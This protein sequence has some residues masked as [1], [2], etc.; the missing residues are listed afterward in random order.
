MPNLVPLLTLYHDDLSLASRVAL[1]VIRN[2]ALEVNVQHVST[3]NGYR[4][5]EMTVPTLIDHSRNDFSLSDSR[6]IASYL[7]ESHQSG[8]S[9][10]PNDI[11]RRAVINQRLYFDAN[12]LVPRLD[13]ITQPLLLGYTKDIPQEKRDRLK[14]SLGYLNGFLELNKWV[15]G[16]ET[17]IADLVIVCTVTTLKELGVRLDEH[18]FVQVWFERCKELPGFEEMEVG[19]KEWAQDVKAKMNQGYY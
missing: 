11:L 10:F 2:L 12:S 17:T 6:T 3:L 15:A 16:Q 5:P 4:S 7:V 18:R 8:H 14:E 13:D 19:A 9:L 1:L